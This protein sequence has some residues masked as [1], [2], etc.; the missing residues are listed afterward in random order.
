MVHCSEKRNILNVKTQRPYHLTK[1]EN[2]KLGGL[3]QKF[4]EAFRS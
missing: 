4:V 2:I 3:Y 1:K